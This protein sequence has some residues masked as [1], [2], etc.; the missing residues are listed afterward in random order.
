MGAGLLVLPLMTTT[1]LV[2]LA[3]G[4]IGPGMAVVSPTLSTLISKLAG[5]HQG[6]TFGLHASAESV[7]QVIGPL[8]GGILFSWYARLP[9]LAA[10]IFL[11][12]MAALTAW[13]RSSFDV[14]RS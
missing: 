12:G 7:G 3:V 4:V 1:P 10:G 8:A 9:Y 2:L 11:V 6:E 13:K 5:N 14:K